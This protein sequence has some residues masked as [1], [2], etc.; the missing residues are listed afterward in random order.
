[1]V[2][3]SREF[4]ASRLQLA[5][6]AYF[7]KQ[8]EGKGAD[9]YV[10]TPAKSRSNQEWTLHISRRIQ[11]LNGEF[12][13]VVAAALDL[14]YFESL[15]GSVKLDYVSPISLQLDDG[16]LVVRQPREE[17]LIGKKLPL[18]V[19]HLDGTEHGDLLTVRTE[20][21]DPGTTT[22]R[23]ISDF[24][25]VLAVG[26]R[27][28]AALTGWRESAQ[29][30]VADA[31]LAA[32]LVLL[33][34]F[35]LLREQRRAEQQARASHQQLREL[36]ASLQTIREEERTS[37]ARELHDELGQQLLRLRM[38]L[39]WLSGRIKTL[40]AP[41][42]EKVEGMK[43][44]IEGT[45]D[46]VRRLTTR[47]RPPVLDDLGLA[48]AM[49]WQVD[50]FSKNSGIAVTASFDVNSAALDPQVATHLFRILQ[51]SL[52][53]IARH[54]E[55][56]QVVVTLAKTATGLRLE[57]SDNGRGIDIGADR[58]AGSHGLI[59]VRERALM[60]GGQV[61]I[62]SFPDAGFALG[63]DIPLAAPELSG[64]KN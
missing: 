14:S 27:D 11:K 16:T 56:T 13:G 38:D 34:A 58:T 45:V 48:D 9:M 42:H 23:H 63:V 8:K 29:I 33:A 31:S 25:L 12:G 55:A 47:L 21:E 59:G 20:G 30:I 37:I 10:G 60:L 19:A 40:S 3:T 26:N 54:A 6:R 46:T 28:Q 32:I 53:N 50:E 24:P 52:T 49:R 36:A 39:S 41:L 44:F 64:E 5:D 2:N 57:V 15:Y 51:E 22:Y 4:P 61:D 18:P 1:M 7:L 17:S 35:F 43:Q 62:V